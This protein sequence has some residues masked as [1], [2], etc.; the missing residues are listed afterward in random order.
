[1]GYEL[2][3]ELIN[4]TTLLLGIKGYYTNLSEEKLNNEKVIE[5]Y[6]NLWK[7]EQNFR[8]SK[9]DLKAR[10]IF[11]NKKQ[12]IETHILIC[13]TALAIAKYVE[14]K[15][16]KSIKSITKTLKKSVDAIIYN[17]LTKK[18]FLIKAKSNDLIEE[19][20]RLI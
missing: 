12:A 3:Q 20:L 16:S 8:I 14:I 1:M 19:I 6:K 7:V 4:K 11:H 5:Q 2:N 18:E 17:P 15:T 10:P 9:S 13:F